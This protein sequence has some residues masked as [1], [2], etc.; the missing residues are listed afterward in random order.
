MAIMPAIS[1][2]KKYIA[3]VVRDSIPVIPGI[4]RIEWW[5]I[6]INC[7]WDHHVL[8]NNLAIPWATYWIGI[9]CLIITSLIYCRPHC[10]RRGNNKNLRAGAADQQ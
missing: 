2:V 3:E 6:V 4:P 7:L 9:V 5:I 10:D 1:R 8:A